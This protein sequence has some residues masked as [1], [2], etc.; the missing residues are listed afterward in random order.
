MATKKNIHRMLRECLILDYFSVFCC[1]NE[2]R[3]KSH[4][5]L[6]VVVVDKVARLHLTF[7]VQSVSI[8]AS[9][10]CALPRTLLDAL[11][12]LRCSTCKLNNLVAC[13][14]AISADIGTVLYRISGSINWI[15]QRRGTL[16]YAQFC[17][18]G[19]KKA[20]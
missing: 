16:N 13:S 12:A 8:F 9:R 20:L 14:T 2:S 4:S 11:A 7:R 19:G 6:R 15:R 5:S 10:R 3:S 17:C 1:A 18:R